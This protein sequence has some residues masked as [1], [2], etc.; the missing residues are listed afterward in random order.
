MA[1]AAV[2]NDPTQASA[3]DSCRRARSI[4][5]QESLGE[6]QH[7]SNLLQGSPTQ[8]F[9]TPTT[10]PRLLGKLRTLVTRPAVSNQVPPQQVTP[11]NSTTS[12]KGAAILLSRACAPSATHDIEPMN[13]SRLQQCAHSATASC[14][15]AS[16]QRVSG[17]TACASCKVKSHTND[18]DQCL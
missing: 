3:A 1:V 2:G 13:M 4:S 7:V 18:W 17:H 15:P 9:S 12:Q 11:A 14:I 10:V 5:A 16:F 8:A 6:S